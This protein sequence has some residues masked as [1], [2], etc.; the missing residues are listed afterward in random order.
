MKLTMSKKGNIVSVAQSII[1]RDQRD[2][3]QHQELSFVYFVLH[4]VEIEF[5]LNAQTRISSRD[6]LPLPTVPI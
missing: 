5:S 6:T 2:D 4:P 3:L 1:R